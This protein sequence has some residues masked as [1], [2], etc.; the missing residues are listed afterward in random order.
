MAL[1]KVTSSN[2][3]PTVEGDSRFPVYAQQFNELVTTLAVGTAVTSLTDSSG[4]TASDTI[5]DI[6]DAGTA[7]SADR[8]PTE[9]AIASLAA[10]VEALTVALRTAG[11]IT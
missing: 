1:K 6:T 10:K 11:V 4:G 3:R 5:A 8:V 9:N 2:F 7:G